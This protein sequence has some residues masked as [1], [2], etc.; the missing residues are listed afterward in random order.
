MRAKKTQERILTHEEACLERVKAEQTRNMLIGYFEYLK[1]KLEKAEIKG[2][3]R[4]LAVHLSPDQPTDSGD[5]PNF[6]RQYSANIF[7]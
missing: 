4:G 2:D 3:V 1:K 5:E 6:L 7:V